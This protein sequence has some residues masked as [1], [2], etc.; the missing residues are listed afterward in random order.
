MTVSLGLSLFVLKK[1]DNLTLPLVFF[2]FFSSCL[3]TVL[4]ILSLF[5]LAGAIKMI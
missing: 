4:L 5:D 1:K 3:I 2:I